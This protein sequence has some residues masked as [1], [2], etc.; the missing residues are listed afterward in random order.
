MLLLRLLL[1][2]LLIASLSHPSLNTTTTSRIDCRVLDIDTTLSLLPH[3]SLPLL[4]YLVLL[5]SRSSSITI[6]SDLI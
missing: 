5:I 4:L 6:R 1:L 2:L 3:P